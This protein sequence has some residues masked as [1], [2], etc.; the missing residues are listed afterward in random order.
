MIARLLGR[1]FSARLFRARRP[2]IIAVEAHGL[3]RA[4]I[5]ACALR[6]TDT[7]QRHGF[8]AFVVG[9]A[10]RDLL[11]A[12]APKDF[13]VAT[14]ATPEEVRAL[15]RRSRLIGR[16]FRIV[17]VM[18]GADTVEVSTF[19]GANPAEDGN[20][21][22]SDEHGRI[23]RD[24]VFGT[25]EQ[26]A[27]R[28]DFSINALFYDPATQQIWD[29][30]DGVRDLKK[31]RLR[32]IGDPEGR[33]RED[34]VRM[35]RAVRLAASCGLEIEAATRRPIARLAGLLGNVPP[36]RLLDELLKLLLSG[37]AVEAVAR[38]RREGLQAGVL[39]LIDAA[40][41]EP[42]G[43]RFITAALTD[44]DERVRTG[45]PV[46]QGFVFA[47]LLWHEVRAALQK[48]E[49]GGEPAMPAMYHAMDHALQRQAAALPL[50]H[51]LSGEMKEMWAMQPRFLQRSG[52]RPY[53]L[54]GH[55]RFRASYDFLRLRCESGEVEPDVGE[56]W[57]RF[58]RAGEA[59]RAQ[60]LVRDSPAPARKRRRRRRRGPQPE[61]GAAPGLK[62]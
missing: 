33:Y 53:R 52:K 55:P 24:N 61:A 28:R 59:E 48:F 3:A 30:H 23:L 36:S 17:H 43:E 18:C 10:V 58:Q 49:A 37:R 44:T 20:D 60:M 45:K 35:L 46:S 7:L 19:R 39:P 38:L 2:K 57:E 50:P 21:R 62:E 16:R 9:G 4:A 47:A 25:Q 22:V 13:D 34:P 14:D 27:T 12:G 31:R 8:A 32:M 54:L 42:W 51:R 40:V 15:F 56:W 29:Y 1:V 5:S 11:L 6:A 26:D 41:A